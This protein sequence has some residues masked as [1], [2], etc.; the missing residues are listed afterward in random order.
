MDIYILPVLNPDGYEFTWRHE[1]LWRKTRSGPRKGKRFVLLEELD[2][3]NHLVQ[4]QTEIEAH[5]YGA[6]A[7]RNFDFDFNGIGSSELPCSDTFSGPFA[8]SEPE[9]KA[10][11]DFLEANKE[12]IQVFVDVHSYSENSYIHME[13]RTSS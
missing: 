12:S 11:A 2:H 8:F 1:R 10:V 3:S 9:S 7:N 6:D 5:C 4:H 13:M